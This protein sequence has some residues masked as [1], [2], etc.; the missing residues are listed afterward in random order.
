MKKSENNQTKRSKAVSAISK[1]MKKAARDVNRGAKKA[2]KVVSTG[3]RPET[4]RL[5]K[6]VVKSGVRPDSALAKWAKLLADPFDRPSGFCPVNYN[7][8]P[9]FIQSLARTTVTNLSCSVP[10]S[11]TTQITLYPGHY[12]PA[13]VGQMVNSG[14]SEMD[15][16]SYHAQTYVVNGVRHVLGPMNAASGVGNLTASIG[17]ITGNINPGEVIGNT[18]ATG[19]AL[20]YDVNLPY[21]VDMGLSASGG[22][23]RWQLVSMGIRIHNLTP[24]I[25]RGGNII[26]V[27]PNNSSTIVSG[28]QSTLEV[29][30][31]FH[32]WGVGDD[33]VQIT[34]IPRAQDLAFWHN[35]LQTASAPGSSAIKAP[36]MMVFLNAGAT[37]QVYSYEI[38]CHWQ[39]AGT[40]LNQVG[41]PSLHH[42]ELKPTIEKTLS[43]ML[44]SHPT[45]SSAPRVVEYAHADDGALSSS[46]VLLEKLSYLKDAAIHSAGMAAAGYYAGRRRAL[47]P[48]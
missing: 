3:S 8:A 10:L 18:N 23:A 16:V 15:G 6:N 46:S 43:T 35:E 30:P 24:E 31:T 44:N 41:G 39:L 2:S 9:S 47:G 45:A 36:A 21:I 29:Y 42:P 17:S 22:H 28:N 20:L 11:T 14:G 13:T 27:Q 19:T 5:I 12:T 1:E 33:G 38:V 4:K 40:Y 48:V 25:N 34:W 32:D 7:P 37:N 26:S